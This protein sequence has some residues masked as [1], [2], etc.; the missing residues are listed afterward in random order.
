MTTARLAGLIA[1]LPEGV[2]E[3]Y[4]HPATAPGYPGA[5]PGYLYEQ[6][7]VALTSK[8]VI[9][10]T[11]EKQIR[12]GSFADFLPHGEGGKVGR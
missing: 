2:S 8:Q 3:I 5:T 7:L 1:R 6:E 11:N 10:L 12:L 9:D 4:L